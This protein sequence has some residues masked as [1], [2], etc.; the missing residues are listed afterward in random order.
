M[1]AVEVAKKVE[2]RGDDRR[3]GGRREGQGASVE[4]DAAQVEADKC[5]VIAA[6][7]SAKQ[8]SVQAD[9]DAAEPLVDQAPR[10]RSTP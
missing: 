2:S 5:A 7:V 10:R 4:N 6:E 9:I 8:V 1:K 3:Q